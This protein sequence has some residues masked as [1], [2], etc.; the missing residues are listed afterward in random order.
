MQL[1]WQTLINQTIKDEFLRNAYVWEPFAKGSSNA[2]FLGRIKPSKIEPH[3]KTVVLR[4]NALAKDTPGVCRD[5][6]ATILNW[7]QPYSWA[8]QI[9]KNEPN[10]GWCLMN[11]Y[12]H[13]AHTKGDSF[14]QFPTQ[15]QS[16]L[17]TAVNQLQCVETCSNH[18]QNYD[19]LLDDTYLPIANSKNDE[20]AYRWIES[21]K[22]DLAT[23][24][25][26]P[27]CLVHHDLHLGN[28][29]ISNNTKMP[30]N[31]LI[32]TILDWEYA[33]VGNPWFDASC[34]SRYLS[35]PTQK[36]HELT[37]FSS[38]N[39]TIFESALK[40]ANEMTGT[41]EKLWYRTRG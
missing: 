10:Q 14:E 41:L 23:L 31:R 5:Q 6:E 8:P 9:I 32:L 19:T 34:L 24:P 36:I 4:I 18:I 39:K 16:Q 20:Q 17:L 35:I 37:V 3:A 29:V 7:I 38:L 22:N 12:E 28:L 25:K 27:N 21:I 11:Y 13:A 2:I 15:H 30:D 40:R 33:S 1:D 26:R